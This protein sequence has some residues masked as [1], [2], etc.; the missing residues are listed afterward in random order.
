MNAQAARLFLRAGFLLSPIAL[1]ACGGG[2]STECFSL[3]RTRCTVSAS[4][5]LNAG[6]A[7]NNTTTNTNAGTL[8]TTAP[9]AVT[10]NAGSGVTYGIGGGTPPYTAT[11]SNTN[12]GTTTVSGTTLS[13]NGVAAGT[14]PIVVVDSLGKTVNIALTVVAQGQEGKSLSVAPGAITVGNCTT[15]IPFIFSGGTGP[16]TVF[17]SDNF[18]VPVSSPLALDPAV[19]S[20]YFTA[21]VKYSREALIQLSPRPVS[22]TLTVLDSQSRTATVT[23]TTPTLPIPTGPEAC[24]SNPLLRVFPES[25][26][27]RESEIRSFEVVEGLRPGGPLVVISFSNPSVAKAFPVSLVSPFTFRVQAEPL[28]L[29]AVKATTLMTVEASDGQRSSVVLTVLPQPKPTP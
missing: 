20:S 9:T 4:T 28:R 13:I 18:G 22:A 2:D 11:S 1:V 5:G 25:A 10:L 14:S 27:F 19:N 23:V 12:V 16:Y 7:N 15:N 21:T 6:S 24:P 17:S 3:D 8:F 26:N 29:G